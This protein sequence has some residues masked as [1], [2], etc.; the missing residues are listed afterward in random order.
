MSNSSKYKKH[1]IEVISSYRRKNDKAIGVRTY[2]EPLS[3]EAVEKRIKRE[4]DRK[5]LEL[6]K[7]WQL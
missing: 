4:V 2:P 7:E 5:Y 6:E 3:K 1:T